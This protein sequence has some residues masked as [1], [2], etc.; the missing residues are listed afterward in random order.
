ML[1]VLDPK[2]MALALVDQEESTLIVKWKSDS[3]QAHYILAPRKLDTR[4]DKVQL[5]CK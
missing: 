5:A 2:G 4:F 3:C 1:G